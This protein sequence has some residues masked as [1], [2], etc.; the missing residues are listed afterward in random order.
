MGGR[1]TPCIDRCHPPDTLANG[2]AAARE[3][4]V[5]V[6]ARIGGD[7]EEMSSYLQRQRSALDDGATWMRITFPTIPG[8][9]FYPRPAV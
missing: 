4:R 2:G 3:A 7:N 9:P 5:L 1:R 8:P 6:L